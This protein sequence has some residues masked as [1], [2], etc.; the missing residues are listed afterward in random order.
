M[1]D[2]VLGIDVSKTTLDTSLLAG[3][4]P[5][6]RSFANSPDGWRQLIAW[7]AKEKVRQVHACLEATGRYSLGIALALHEAGHVVSLVNPAQIRD[8]AR[9]KLGRNKTDQVDAA[10]IRE[11]A[12]L[13]KP[14]PWTPPSPALRR[15][16]ELQ[17]IRA[18]TVA[19]LTEWKNRGTS[20][21]ADDRALALAKATI[22]HFTLEAVDQAIAE[23]IDNDPELCAKR[24]LLVS[25]SGVGETLAGIVLAELP[26]PD[27]LG[28]SAAVAAYAGLNPRQ[29]Q[30]G[31][32]INRPA[33]ISK[34]GNAVLRTALYMPAL[35]AMRYNPAIA[36]L[37]DRLKAQGRLK[38]KQIVVAAMRKLLVICFGVLKSG[39]EF[40]PTIAM[41]Q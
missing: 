12:E 16:C 31:T 15:L 33:R 21:M 3:A 14:R 24:T 4:K 27:V 28:S 7:L 13:F 30:S 20:G 18:G 37:V 19:S 2:A 39:K 22:Q 11:Y 41:G 36:A 17:T 1:T 10:H 25:I 38:G 29:H 5:R 23:T 32:S 8:F 34:I 26:G 35:S 40:D 9:T 6:S